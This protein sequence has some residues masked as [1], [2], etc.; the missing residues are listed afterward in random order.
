MG[1]SKLQASEQR[2][3]LCRAEFGVI[4]VGGSNRVMV[5]ELENENDGKFRHLGVGDISTPPHPPP[6]EWK[7]RKNVN[8]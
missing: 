1:P 8:K 6:H 7:E 3:N 5:L 4:G 2:V